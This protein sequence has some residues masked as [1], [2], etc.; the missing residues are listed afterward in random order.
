MYKGCFQRTTVR[1][2]DAVTLIDVLTSALSKEMGCYMYKC[3]V[4]TF[5]TPFHYGDLSKEECRQ[6]EAQ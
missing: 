5:S 2:A 3:I 4:I 6:P 1:A